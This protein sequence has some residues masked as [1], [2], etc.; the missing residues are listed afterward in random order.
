MVQKRGD[1]TI[2][3]KKNPRTNRT[4]S[5]W[6]SS[7][8]KCPTKGVNANENPCR[9]GKAPAEELE[10]QSIFQKMKIEKKID[11][12]NHLPTIKTAIPYLPRKK[13]IQT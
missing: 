2:L 9:V 1:L 6:T 5:K 8:L 3:G 10:P 4:E 7:S 12:N 13:E 11:P